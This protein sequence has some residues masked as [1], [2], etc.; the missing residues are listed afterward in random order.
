MTSNPQ[1]LPKDF[2]KSNQ[3]FGSYPLNLVEGRRWGA[4]VLRERRDRFEERAQ[5]LVLFEDEATQQIPILE[6]DDA[7]TVSD[8]NLLSGQ[9]LLD[10]FQA[11][12]QNCA[13]DST[14]TCRPDPLYRAV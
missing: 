6:V 1:T 2:V 13:K 9:Q 8:K 14:P 10:W 4:F 5:S 3:T 12:F 11:D 7:G